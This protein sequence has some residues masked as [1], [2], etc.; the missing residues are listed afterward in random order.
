MPIV[1]GFL[2]KRSP[3]TNATVHSSYEISICFD[4]ANCFDSTTIKA[5]IDVAGEN[6]TV[7]RFMTRHSWAMFEDGVARQGFPTSPALANIALSAIDYKLGKALYDIWRRALPSNFY[8]DESQNRGIAFD[9]HD[10]VNVPREIRLKSFQNNYYIAFT[11]YADDITISI[12]NYDLL[13]PIMLILTEWF[14]DIAFD[15]NPKKTRVQRSAFGNRIITGVSVGTEIS[16]S[17]KTR[18]KLRAA[19]HQSNHECANGLSEWCKLK[20]P[21]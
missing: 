5:V 17:R 8:F 10:F 3:V 4:I 16:S 11:R 1:H 21:C 15:I 2:P 20:K 19:L 7:S 12:N 14:N 9:F 6:N 13:E 18:R